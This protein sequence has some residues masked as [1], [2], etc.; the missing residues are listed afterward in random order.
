MISKPRPTQGLATRL[1]N[2][3]R[4]L[5]LCAQSILVFAMKFRRNQRN[6][7]HTKSHIK[8]HPRTQGWL[9]IAWCNMV[10]PSFKNTAILSKRTFRWTCPF[11][12]LGIGLCIPLLRAIYGFYGSH[13]EAAASDASSGGVP[14]TWAWNGHRMWWR[15]D[16]HHQPST[17]CLRPTT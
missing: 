10:Q 1:T 3:K 7:W 15:R 2:A 11:C 17:L 12:N 5:C 9:G 14:H 8:Y 6:M 16:S 13:D 4:S